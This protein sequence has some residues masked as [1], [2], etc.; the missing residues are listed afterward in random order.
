MRL[1]MGTSVRACMGMYS[2]YI[3]ITCVSSS[4]H[5]CAN[6][7]VV[8]TCFEHV[9]SCPYTHKTST[10][11]TYT[12]HVFLSSPKNMQAKLFS[13]VFCSFR[14][15]E[16]S[17]SLLQKIHSSCKNNENEDR[18]LSLRTHIRKYHWKARQTHS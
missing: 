2:V 8:N 18:C 1:C 15:F 7:P 4:I 10:Y 13:S 16:C 3:N 14:L 6:V 9:S 12:H 17:S 11:I 5:M